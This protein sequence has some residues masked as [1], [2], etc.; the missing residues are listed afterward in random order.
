MKYQYHIHTSIIN[1]IKQGNR[2][3]KDN[4][5]NIVNS[6]KLNKRCKKSTR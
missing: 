6:I 5:E 1:I 2:N 4:N 3:P